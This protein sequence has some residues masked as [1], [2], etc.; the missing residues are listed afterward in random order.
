ML[1]F[2]QTLLS[3]LKSVH[4]PEL[5]SAEQKVYLD[6]HL[7]RMLFVFNTLGQFNL[8]AEGK[9]LD[10]GAKPYVL[11]YLSLAY[12]KWHYT[13][14]GYSIK[15]LRDGEARRAFYHELPVLKEDLELKAPQSSFKFPMWQVNI[16]KDPEPF[17]DA[18]FDA[19]V[20]TETVEHLVQDP[21]FLFSEIARLLKPE[22]KF[23][24]SVPNAIYWGRLLKLLA[25][26]NIDDPYSVHGPYGRHNR[27]YTVREARKLCEAAGL[28]V[29]QSSTYNFQPLQEGFLKKSLRFLGNLIFS[30]FPQRRGK[31]VFV[32]A[33]K[34]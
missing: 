27:N 19:I 31:T 25:G 34:K 26:K 13:G 30:P 29:L 9:V 15:E 16:E 14:V 3:E 23:I 11:A 7:R 20:C 24:F 32:T 4:F 18:G 6:E 5:N 10:L 12:A 1:A 28:K 17:P 33:M 8:P 22:G 21:S 2:S